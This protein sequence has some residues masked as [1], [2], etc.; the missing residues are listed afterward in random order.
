MI[1]VDTKFFSHVIDCIEVQKNI[2]LKP[3]KEK[4]LWQDRIDKTAKQCRQLI[5]DAVAEEKKSVIRKALQTKP[6]SSLF[7]EKIG[8]LEEEEVE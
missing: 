4:I 7:D 8:S 3:L 5:E 6:D 2:H 1:C